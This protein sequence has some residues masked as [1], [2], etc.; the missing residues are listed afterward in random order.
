MIQVFLFAGK[1]AKPHVSLNPGPEVN[2]G[3]RV[4]IT[5]SVEITDHL[6]GM[7]VLQ[8]TP[9]PFRMQRYSVSETETFTIPKTNLS[10]G[11][12]YHCLFQ[13]K[14]PSK[15]IDMLGDPVELKVTG[16]TVFTCCVY[17]MP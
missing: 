2:F 7:F 9:G 3:D 13:K 8:K 10:H 16:Q 11:G 14:I 5:C 1:L 4:E 6:G 15:T 17:D 12:L